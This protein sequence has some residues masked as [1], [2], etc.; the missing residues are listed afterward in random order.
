[1]SK[2]TSSARKQRRNYE[3][4]LKKTNPSAYREWKTDSLERGK[5][6]HESNVEAVAQ[7]EE[8]KYQNLQANLMI[9]L[10]E[11]GLTDKEIDR[12]VEIWAMTIKPWGSPEP[13]LSLRKARK[14]YNQSTEN[15]KDKAN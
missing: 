8:T 14:L 9:K 15:G 5:N 12:E 13:A 3:K 11:Q 4:W 7:A 2:T 1:M 6:I 10:K